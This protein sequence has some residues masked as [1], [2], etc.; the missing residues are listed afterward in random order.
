LIIEDQLDVQLSAKLLLKKHYSGVDAVDQPSN[1]VQAMK[2]KSYEVV[3]LDMNFSRGE[4]SGKEGIYWLKKIL[5]ASPNTSVVMMTA[6]GDVDLAIEA[7]KSGAFDFVLKP[8]R[9]DKLLDTIGQAFFFCTRRKEALQKKIQA[10]QI[11][12]E[13]EQIPFISVSD[14]MKKVLAMVEKVAKTDANILVQGENGTGKEI[15]ARS[16]HINS[17]R[18]NY[19]FVKVDLAAIPET[20]FETELFGHKM[21]AIPEA[22]EDRTG[23]FE[24]AAGGTLFLDE[25]GNLSLTLQAKLLHAIQQKSIQRLG[26]TQ[27]IKTDVRIVCASSMNLQEMCTKQQFRKDLLYQVNTVEIDIP[28]LRER[29]KD[30]AALGEYFL[31]SFSKKYHKGKISISK[32]GWQ[33]IERYNW[34]GNVRELQHSIE[35]AVILSEANEI[36]PQDLVISEAESQVKDTSHLLNLEELEKQTIKKALS[37]HHGNIS[38]AAREL[39]LTRAALYRR[40]EKY[41]I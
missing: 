37:I 23:W 2:N 31:Q 27:N 4:T 16:I 5:Q 30:I 38:H 26:S 28:P 29:R 6:Y 33:S 8:W 9:N 32:E 10:G 24:K 20:M 1:A 41:G 7:I 35:R 11:L 14:E 12:S 3:M 18:C 17:R 36:G 25:I 39:G 22:K 19:P 15:V 40:M 34:P 21:G 13:E